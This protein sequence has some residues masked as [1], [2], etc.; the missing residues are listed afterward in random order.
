MTTDSVAVISF[1]NL[2]RE[3]VA[4]VGGKNSSLGEMVQSLAR[5]M[6][7]EASSMQTGWAQ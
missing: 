6:R 2:K 4:L 1:D 5:P 3:D 7:S